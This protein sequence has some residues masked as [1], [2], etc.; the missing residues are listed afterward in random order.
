MQFSIPSSPRKSCEE[1][2]YGLCGGGKTTVCY[3]Y[4]LLLPKSCGNASLWW[5]SWWTKKLKLKWDGWSPLKRKTNDPPKYKYVALL[6]QPKNTIASLLIYEQHHPVAATLT[7][8]QWL[9]MHKKDSSH[10]FSMEI[11]KMRH[12][13]NFSNTVVYHLKLIAHLYIS[14]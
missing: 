14:V 1:R 10:I 5:P 11:Q 6:L 9:K 4:F 8:T 12:F 3:Y 13:C 2:V 7:T